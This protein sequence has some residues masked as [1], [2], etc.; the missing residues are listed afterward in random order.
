METKIMNAINNPEMLEGLYRSDKKAFVRAFRSIY[1]EISGNATAGFWKARLDYEERGTVKIGFTGRNFL[2]LILVCAVCGILIKLPDIIPIDTSF[3]F[4]QKNAAIIVLFGLVAYTML[5]RGSVN[6][7]HWLIT[8]VTFI[9]SLLYINLLPSD[10]ASDTITLAY[11]HLPLL[12]WYIWGLTYIEF[13]FKDLS[14]RMD[15]LRH[16]G[17]VVILFAIIALSGGLLTAL[18][19]GLFSAIDINVERFYSEYVIIIGAVSAPVVASY[20]LGVFPGVTSKT[21]S[22]IANIFSPLVLITLTGYLIGM[23]ITGKDPY[24]DREF[25][26]VFNCLLIGVMALIVF[27][28][29]ESSGKLARFRGVILFLLSAVTLI[30]DMIA[31]TAILYRLSEF[32]FTPNRIAVLGFNILV[33]GNLI[34]ISARLLRVVTGKS[35]MGSVE[36]AIAGYLPVYAVWAFLIS[37][38][39]PLLFGMR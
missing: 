7:R 14:K 21:A 24:D 22:I 28:V 39:F 8:K 34:S 25:L 6:I 13:D 10:N 33:F 11:L 35:D 37:F 23:A 38:G 15:F 16:N 5:S 32:G 4:Y 19:I 30:V 29:S 31:L 26:L 27:A 20:V 12:L 1:P 3:H 17:D 2:F 36:G 9:I 18:T